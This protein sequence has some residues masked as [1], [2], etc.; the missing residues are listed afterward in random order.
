MPNWCSTTY[1]FYGG[2]EERDLLFNTIE[3]LKNL[4]EPRVE[5]GFGKLW[6]GCLIDALGGNWQ[7]VYCRG[8][9]VDYANYEDYLEI[10]TETAWGEMYDVRQY[11]QVRFPRLI[12]YY[13]SEEP[14]MGEYYTNDKDGSIFHTKYAVDI[15]DYDYECFE[16]LEDT[17]KWINSVPGYNFNVEPTVESIKEAFDK[18]EEENEDCYIRFIEYEYDGN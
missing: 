5:N 7:N 13:M 18:Y 14:G 8:E 15:E 4:P 6:L 2:K 9:I 17:A 3:E 12:I 1:R 16:T 10:D 11:L